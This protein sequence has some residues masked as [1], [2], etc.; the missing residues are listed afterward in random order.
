M[1]VMNA[2]EISARASRTIA[3]VTIPDTVVVKAAIELVL[4]V[5]DELLFHHSRRVYLWGMLKS[6][7]L[8]HSPAA[9][10]RW[11][12]FSAI[13]RRQGTL[14]DAHRMAMRT[15]AVA[16]RRAGTANCT[17]TRQPRRCR[18]S[19]CDRSPHPQVC[20]QEDIGLVATDEKNLAVH[21]FAAATPLLLA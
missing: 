20:L 1:P 16:L 9:D 8:G 21:V 2:Q 14:G 6:R 3:G 15:P 7:R 18:R 13:F 19:F 4:D 11:W 17:G 5:D 12:R 10:V